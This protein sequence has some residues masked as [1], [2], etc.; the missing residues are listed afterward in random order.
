MTCPKC[1][2]DALTIVDSRPFGYITRRRRKCLNCTE[3]FNTL[4]ITEAEW[5][6]YKRKE[7]FL[8]A[9]AKVFDEQKKKLV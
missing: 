3:R 8:E 5:N 1:G 7:S 9:I 6:D 2:A 4:E